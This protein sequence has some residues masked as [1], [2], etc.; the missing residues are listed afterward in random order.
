M[1]R[2]PYP[3]D[4]TDGQWKLIEPL[5]PDA[6]S[7]R[8]SGGRPRKTNLREVLNALFYLVRSGCQWRMIPHEFPPWRTCYNY[9]R[10]WIRDG[11]LDEIAVALRGEVRTSSG[12]NEQ[13][14]VAAIDSQS[15]KTTEQGGEER[16]YDGG[17]KVSGRKRH[18]LVD[19]L[20]MLLAVLVTSAAVDDGVAAKDLLEM[21]ESDA[22]PRLRTVYGDNKYHNHGLYAW[23]D[24]NVDYR[25]HIVRRPEDAQG[26]VRL[27]QRWVVE[28]T[29]SWL[30][31]SR[32]LHKDCEKL[33][34]TSEA[35]VKIAMIHLMVRRLASD[36]PAQE[37]GYTDRENIA[38]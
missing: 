25:L 19:S 10:A 13:P 3:T 37:F 22:F 11:T 31:R 4:L 16:G 5:L 28:R 18:I 32:R 23:I 24:D 8:K 6:K 15:V 20:G 7:D 14:R 17:K 1:E 2:K 21:V 26:F 12:R 30:G 27:P 29:F 33:T 38:A 34:I 36:T 9:Y 35:M